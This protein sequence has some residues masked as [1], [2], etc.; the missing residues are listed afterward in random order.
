MLF[1]EGL[2]YVILLTGICA[3]GYLCF[4]HPE[5]PSEG[6]EVTYGRGKLN[7]NNK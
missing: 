2:I 7:G 5:D 6:L 1:P 4:S 3:F